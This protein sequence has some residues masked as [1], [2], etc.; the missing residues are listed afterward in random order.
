MIFE[1]KTA[2]KIAQELL[3]KKAVVLQTQSP[4]TWASGWKSP[5]Y[6]DNRKLLSFPESRNLVA[7]QFAELVKNKFPTAKAIAG[8]ATAGIAHACLLADRLQLP[9]VYV[10]A[11]AK[12]H[13]LQNAVE[14]VL[15]TKTPYVVVEDL[16]STGGSTLAAVGALR[17]A[18][19]E[20]LGAV[21]IFSYQFPQAERAFAAANCPFYTLSDYVH[22]LEMARANNYISADEINTLLQ[23]R[24]APDLWQQA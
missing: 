9:M 17:Q 1:Q 18:G 13:G 12:G 24:E 4:F 23:W 22:L 15:D 11:T 8:V 10:R 2:V 19:A 16:I 6:C 14:G 20:V 7:E 5:I 3:A 21:A